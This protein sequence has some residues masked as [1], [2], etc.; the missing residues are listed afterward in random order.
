MHM[1]GRKDLSSAELET[2]QKS[3]ILKTVTTTKW[4]VHTSEEAQVNFHDFELFV[5]VQI[6]DDTPAVLSLA[7]S[8]KNTVVPTSGPVVKSSIWPRIGKQFCARRKN[9]S[10][11]SP[12][13]VIKLERKLVFYIGTAGH[14]GYESSKTTKWRYARSSVGKPRR[15]NKNQ[16]KSKEGR[17]SSNELSIARSPRMVSGVHRWSRTYR[18]ACFRNHF[19]RFRFET[20][21]ESGNQE[22]W[23]LYSLSQRPKLRN[24]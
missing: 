2:L 19:S 21:C 10:C 14:I 5:T 4:E 6:L 23:Y 17:Q 24:M 13:I 7:S 18:S 20:T 16:K 22:T 3:R 9:R 8:A 12:R 15:S 11:R 1:L